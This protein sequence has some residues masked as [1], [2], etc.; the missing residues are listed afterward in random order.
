[1]DQPPKYPARPGP[2]KLEHH[3]KAYYHPL[4]ISSSPASPWVNTYPRE[5]STPS[6]SSPPS[7]P[8][9]APSASSHPVPQAQPSAHAACSTGRPVADAGDRYRSCS[10]IGPLTARLPPACGGTIMRG[11]V[12]GP[13]GCR[14]GWRGRF[15]GS[16]SRALWIRCPCVRRRV[17]FP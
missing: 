13:I 11:R 4:K 5:K 10:R 12:S 3:L 1:M 9:P 17:R 14:G 7:S 15:R 2:A 6:P 16:R 8:V